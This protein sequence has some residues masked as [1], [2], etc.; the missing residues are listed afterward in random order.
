[1]IRTRDPR[2]VKASKVNDDD[3][4]IEFNN[5]LLKSVSIDTA[6]YRLSCAK[7]YSHV[8]L[9][10]NATDLLNLS[11]EKRIHVM[12]S[13][14]NLAKFL[15]I[16]DKWKSTIN[17]Y[18][19]KWSNENG[20]DTFHKILNDKN[21]YNTML[22]W[23]KQTYQNLP[24]R[25]GNL[26][27]FNTLTGLRPAEACESIK[28]IGYGSEE[29]FNRYRMILE[30]FRFPE[31]FIRKTKNAYI[32]IVTDKILSVAKEVKEISYPSVKL[33]IKRRG[34]E[35]HLN[36]CR[37]IFAT[38][39]RNHGIEQEVIDLLQGRIPKSIFV[40]HYYKPD[41]ESFKKIRELL[42]ELYSIIIN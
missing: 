1:V 2:H 9:E 17:R 25:Y 16:Y 14:S 35:M 3:F 36:Y 24:T 10:E 15:G 6:R 13:L 7:K 11:N 37:K 31:V 28:M 4:W 34:M 12:K 27:L 33:A 20:V 22:E 29:Y 38:Y 40:R 23:V 41:Y 5:Y 8:L 42:N 19:L 32:S 26:L 21:D 18:Q 39:L 30:H